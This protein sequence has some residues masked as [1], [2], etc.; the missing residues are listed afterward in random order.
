[1]SPNHTFSGLSRRAMLSAL[2]MLPALSGTLLS[3]SASAQTATSGSPLPSWNDGA[4]KQSILDFVRATTDRASSNYIAPEERIA[5]FDQDGTLWVEQPLPT[6]GFY[7]LERIPAVVA[8]HPGFKNVEPFKT[9]LSGNREAL[10]KLTVRDLEKIVAMSLTGM[11]TDEFEAD[12]K[13]WLATAT[14]ARWK[15]P[16]TELIYQPM[17]G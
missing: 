10:A 15:R 8:K 2:A 13:K 9:V 11:T 1:M 17:L 12:V 16:Y 4:A 7:C 3:V 5:V 6:Q 14:D